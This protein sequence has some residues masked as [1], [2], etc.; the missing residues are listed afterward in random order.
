MQG[1]VE[2]DH[3]R[4]AVLRIV[5]NVGSVETLAVGPETLGDGER[6]NLD[7]KTVADAFRAA[8][9]ATGCF[10]K[11]HNGSQVF[12]PYWGT[13]THTSVHGRG[14]Y[15]NF[16]PNYPYGPCATISSTYTW[17]YNSR[18][19]TYAWGFSSFHDGVTNFVFLDGSVRPIADGIDAASWT[20]LCTPDGGEIITNNP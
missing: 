16:A 1:K 4:T 15:N 3:E 18:T 20:A 6:L 5:A 12:G 8:G 10:G 19:C 13:G 11:W 2:S 9:Y 14:W 7:E 17:G